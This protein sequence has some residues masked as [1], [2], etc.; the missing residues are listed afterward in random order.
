MPPA[1]TGAAAGGIIGG[2]IGLL[3]GIGALAI[4]GLGAFVA[5]GPIMAALGG[6]GVGGGI[7]LIVGALTGLGIPEYEAQRYEDRLKSGGILISIH[8][9]TSEEVNKAKHILE[10]NKIED[11]ATGREKTSSRR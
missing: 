3:A 8:C 1:A 10:Q 6:S 7:G 11:V 9:N 2:T 5:A 4:P